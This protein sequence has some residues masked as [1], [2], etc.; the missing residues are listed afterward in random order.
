MPQ[1]PRRPCFR[2]RACGGDDAAECAAEV[3]QV[4]LVSVAGA[5]DRRLARWKWA[6]AGA[7]RIRASTHRLG[8]AMRRRDLQ[9]L[10]SPH[11]GPSARWRSTTERTAGFGAGAASGAY[12][13]KTL[14]NGIGMTITAWVTPTVGVVA[15]GKG[16]H[17]LVEWLWLKT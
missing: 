8:I 1:L 7:V 4:R 16:V 15:V 13:S 14:N 6:E 5:E 3:V 10:V 17:A 2:I 11:G 9:V 12:L